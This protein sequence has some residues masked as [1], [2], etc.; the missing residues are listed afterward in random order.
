MLLYGEP[1]SGKT[2]LARAVA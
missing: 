1:G 2:L